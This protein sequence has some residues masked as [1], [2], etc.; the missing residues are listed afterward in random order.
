MA[1]QTRQ[2]V[3]VTQS[4][5]DVRSGTDR[6]GGCGQRGLAGPGG[7]GVGEQLGAGAGQGVESEVAAAFDPIVMLLGEN[8]ADQADQGVAVGEDARPGRSFS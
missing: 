6:L 8:G 3:A 1:S 2:R 7:V 5:R 4:S